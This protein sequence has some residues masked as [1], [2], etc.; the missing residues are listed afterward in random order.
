VNISREEFKRLEAQTASNLKSSAEDR[1]QSHYCGFAHGLHI[2]FWSF[3]CFPFVFFISSVYSFYIGTLTWYNVL[4]WYTEEKSL[5]YQIMMV[6]VLIICYPIYIVCVTFGLGLYSAFDQ[7]C[8]HWT[9]WIRSVH[10]LE[11]GFYAWLC[12]QLSLEECSPYTEVIIVN[13]LS[14]PL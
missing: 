3:L 11:K 7:I 8:L 6:P 1:P 9:H 10:D 2:L 14:L 13:Q 12:S 5:S 4:S